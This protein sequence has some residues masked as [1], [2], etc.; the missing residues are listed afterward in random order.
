M[1]HSPA[2]Y[3]AGKK[4]LNILLHR[5]RFCWEFC[6]QEIW[7]NNGALQCEYGWRGCWQAI[8]AVEWT[9]SSLQAQWSPCGQRYLVSYTKVHSHFNMRTESGSVFVESQY[10]QISAI[11]PSAHARTDRTPLLAII[12]ELW[13]TH[14]DGDKCYVIYFSPVAKQT[15]NAVICFI[16]KQI[17][18]H[19]NSLKE[20][21]EHM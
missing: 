21:G 1:K 10:L 2:S 19:Q 17:N 12:H 8:Q 20:I 13:D 7:P 4:V 3:A 5:V 18:M 14:V 16:L 11:P 9:T 6:Q 15:G